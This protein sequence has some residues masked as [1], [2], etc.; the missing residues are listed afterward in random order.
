M[1]IMFI[2]DIH[3]IV[4]NL[5][6]IK[7]I[8]DNGNFDKLVVLGDL[9]YGGFN[10][11]DRMESNNKIVRDFLNSYKDIIICMRGN[12]DSDLDITVSD[13][14]INEGLSLINTDGIYIYLTHGNRYNSDNFSMKGILMYGHY[15]IPSITKTDDMVY[16][17]VGS[18]SL[19]RDGSSASYGV[20]EDKKIILYTIDG[21]VIDSVY[22]E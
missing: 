13:F 5:D 3:G 2:S 10:T 14:P 21:D 17:C 7:N 11:F 8:F 15:H 12:C 6:K 4:T 1:K 16:V 20:Y 9:Y 18:V 19:P 22:L